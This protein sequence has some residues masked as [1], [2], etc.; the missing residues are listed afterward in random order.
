MFIEGNV[1]NKHYSNAVI[2]R[3][4]NYRDRNVIS[5]IGILPV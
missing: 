3:I 2:F 4:R 1:T 5:E